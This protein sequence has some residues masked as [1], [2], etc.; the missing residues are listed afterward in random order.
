MANLLT[1]RPP[2]VHNALRWEFPGRKVNFGEDPRKG[3]EWEIKEELVIKIE[4]KEILLLLRNYLNLV[5]KYLN[6]FLH[7]IHKNSQL[8][9][10]I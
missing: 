3:L 6:K 10:L 7:N 5:Q 1:Q 9:F 8:H 4:V 2:G